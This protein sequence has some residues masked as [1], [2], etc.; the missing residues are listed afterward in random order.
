MQKWKTLQ[1][2]GAWIA[3]F[4]GVLFTAVGLL[5]VWQIIGNENEIMVKSL[6][7]LAILCFTGVVFNALGR[8]GESAEKVHEGAPSSITTSI[9][10]ILLI[11][12]AFLTIPHAAVLLYVIWTNLLS[13]DLFGRAMLSF[14]VL[15]IGTVVVIKSIE[16]LERRGTKQD[17]LVV[18]LQPQPAPPQP[19]MPQQYVPPQQQYPVYPPQV[20]PG[21]MP[22]VA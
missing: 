7:S 3:I 1:R 15:L 16:I 22:P 5:G 18:T 6:S 2:I 12:M 9:R 20:P 17:P 11:S 14:F 8:L 21:G 10:N 13:S 4:A 19:V